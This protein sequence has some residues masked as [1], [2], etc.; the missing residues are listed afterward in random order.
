M[1]IMSI[2]N[3]ITILIILHS[4]DFMAYVKGFLTFFNKNFKLL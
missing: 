4:T 1:P 2:K 3:F